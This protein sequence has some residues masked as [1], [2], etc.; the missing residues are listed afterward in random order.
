MV[1]ISDSFTLE[2]TMALQNE[3]SSPL[4]LCLEPLCEHFILEPGQ[5]VKVHAVFNASTENRNFTIAPND[6]LLTIYAPGEISGFIDCFVVF[7]G[8]RLEPL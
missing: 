2:A 5:K 7:E 3:G 1:K 8:K 4:R 6:L